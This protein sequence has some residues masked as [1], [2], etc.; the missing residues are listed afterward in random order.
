MKVLSDAVHAH[1]GK[2]VGIIP[3]LINDK[4]GAD[5]HLSELLL[6]ED[7]RTRKQEM[8]RRADAYIVLP[9][10]VG[11]MDE[12]YDAIV[13]KELG[14]H[15][16]PIVIVN[17]NKYYDKWLDFF[18]EGVR[19]QFVRDAKQRLFHV[20]GEVEEIFPYLASYNPIPNEDKWI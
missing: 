14:Y 6:V 5:P 3:R 2:T 9:G 18:A 19:Q 7:M 8:E 1:R 16:K 4:K 10:G 13:Q 15:S 20:V 12:L 17:I 11:T